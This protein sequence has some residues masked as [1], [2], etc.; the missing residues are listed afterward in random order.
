MFGMRGERRKGINQL[1]AR[2]MNCE[3]VVRG[4]R[5]GVTNAKVIRNR[6]SYENSSLKFCNLIFLI[7]KEKKKPG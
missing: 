7:F 4:A 3:R 1:L 6:I 2:Q 5:E